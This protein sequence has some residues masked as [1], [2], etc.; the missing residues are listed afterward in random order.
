[1]SYGDDLI[2]VVV[3][4]KARGRGGAIPALQTVQKAEDNRNRKYQ[5]RMIRHES[6]EAV[7]V[8]SDQN[9]AG[10]SKEIPS[11]LHSFDGCGDVSESCLPGQRCAAKYP[12]RPP[13]NEC[14]KSCL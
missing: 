4:T 9:R 8:R 5:T 1:M 3:R 10:P 7:R 12:K 2:A 14:K 6:V 13:H 11:P